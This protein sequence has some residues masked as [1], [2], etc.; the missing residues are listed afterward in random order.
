MLYRYIHKQCVSFYSVFRYF[1]L[2]KTHDTLGMTCLGAINQLRRENMKTLLWMCGLHCYHQ[3]PN[4]RGMKESEPNSCRASSFGLYML[5][6]FT[7]P[8]FLSCLILNLKDQNIPKTYYIVIFMLQHA[9]NRCFMKSV[10]LVPVRLNSAI[11]EL[12]NVISCGFFKWY[13]R[14]SKNLH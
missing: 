14:A 6:Y 4:K 9:W 11:V 1:D 2:Y 5:F 10:Q 7:I 12:K 13:G 3:Q 8:Y